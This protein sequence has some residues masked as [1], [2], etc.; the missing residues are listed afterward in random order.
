MNMSKEGNVP[1]ILKDAA[2]AVIHLKEGD[3]LVLHVPADFPPEQH[4]AVNRSLKRIIETTG[5][6]NVAA[7]TLHEGMTLDVVPGDKLRAEIAEL[8]ATVAKYIT[9]KK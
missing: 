1:E 4:D 2:A 5:R 9:D 6:K 3:I 8:K 7:V